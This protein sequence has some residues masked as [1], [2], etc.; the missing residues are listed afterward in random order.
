MNHNL[1]NLKTDKII[2][3]VLIFFVLLKLDKNFMKL[4]Y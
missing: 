3:S 4:F 2:L 1:K